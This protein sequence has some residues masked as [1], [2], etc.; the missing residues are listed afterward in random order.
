MHYWPTQGRTTAHVAMVRLIKQFRPIAVV[1]NG[2][3]VDLPKIGRH[4]SIGWE[5]RP[6][7]IEELATAQARLREFERACPIAER[8]WTAGNHDLR[9]ESYIANNAPQ[10][11]GVQGVHLHD[12]FPEWMPAWMIEVNAHEGPG[13]VMI[14]HRWKGGVHAAHGNTVSSGRSIVTGH[15]HSAQVTCWTDYNGTRYG[16]DT[17]TLAVPFDEAFIHYTEANPVNWRSAVTVLTFYNGRLLLPEQLHV[18]DESQR[19]T[20]FRGKVQQEEAA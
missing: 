12:H 9:F 11:A 18:L 1:A 16:V 15:L 6:E 3:V 2:D 13:A 8:F 7:V 19:L 5:K 17:G 4:P 10:F 14:K 20:M